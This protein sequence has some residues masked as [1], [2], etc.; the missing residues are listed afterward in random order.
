M[1][2]G[3]QSDGKSTLLEVSLPLLGVDCFVGELIKTL[4]ATR[5]LHSQF[6]VCFCQAFLGFRFNVR[7]VE[8]GTRRPLVVQML[9][10]PKHIEP[11]CSFKDEDRSTYSDPI[12]P[13][14]V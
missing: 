5:S 3:G 7:E 2:V 4:L 1:V 6:S 12:P 14:Q 9:N 13:D 11:L 8:M 10:N